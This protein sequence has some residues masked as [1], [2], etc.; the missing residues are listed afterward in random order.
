MQ[1][2]C[3]FC[4]SGHRANLIC[5]IHMTRFC[6]TCMDIHLTLENDTDADHKIVAISVYE[7]KLKEKE[8]IDIETKREI[9]SALRAKI[10]KES[11]R[12][13]GFIEDIRERLMKKR[14]ILIK[15]ID[16]V[17]HKQIENALDAKDLA[18]TQ[19]ESTIQELNRGFIEN[20]P[21]SHLVQRFQS[22]DDTRSLIFAEVRN[23]TH[24]KYLDTA[25]RQ[26]LNYSI[27]FY[28][29][30]KPISIFYFKA[31]TNKLFVFNALNNQT[32]VID[33]KTT[34]KDYAAWCKLPGDLVIYSGGW[35]KNVSSSEVFLVDPSTGAVETK[36]KMNVGRHQHAI[37]YYDGSIYAFGGATSTGITN[38]CEK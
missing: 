27:E 11:Q 28:P 14:E 25:L 18:K 32:S 26:E 7:Q 16:K 8:R 13:D 9:S 3:E 35:V 33:T 29:S 37:I 30:A 2:Y 21:I 19:L 15:K 22:I 5:T 23:A 38:S 1:D 34:F 31:M 4:S 24:H 20:T 10:I 36:P 6:E 12:V 17:I